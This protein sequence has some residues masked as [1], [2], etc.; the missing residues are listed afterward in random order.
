M[1]KYSLIIQVLDVMGM[2]DKHTPRQQWCGD[3][4]VGSCM[5]VGVATSLQFY[6]R[7]PSYSHGTAFNQFHFKLIT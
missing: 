2:S 1:L 3:G 6:G 7:E 4:G 5:Q